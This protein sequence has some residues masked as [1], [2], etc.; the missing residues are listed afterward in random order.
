MRFL[1][2]F[3]DVTSGPVALVGCGEHAINKL[4]LLLRRPRDR[5]LVSR[6]YRRRRRDRAGGGQPRASSKSIS[7]IR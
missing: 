6:P 7:T 3:M 2:V 4:R 1:P 5:A